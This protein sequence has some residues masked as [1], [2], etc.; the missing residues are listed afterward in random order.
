MSWELAFKGISSLT[1]VSGFITVF[2]VWRKY[3]YEKNRDLYIR[4]LN[5]VYAP[6]FGMVVK[7]EEVRSSFMKNVSFNEAPILSMNTEKE[8]ISKKGYSRTNTP[9]IIH[10]DKFLEHFRKID[11]GLTSPE[12]IELI[13]RFE[14]LNSMLI[15]KEYALDGKDE[16]TKHLVDIERKLIKN[17]VDDYYLHVK[18]IGLDVNYE[19]IYI[20]N[21]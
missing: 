12:L 1:V 21:I 17:I 8:T 14:V 3:V 19:K 16:L 20:A 18:K 6:L 4:R 7:Q 11:L 10:R 5:E 13:N 15:E 9:G 2:F